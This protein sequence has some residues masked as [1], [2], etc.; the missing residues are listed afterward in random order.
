M[1]VLNAVLHGEIHKNTLFFALNGDLRH[2]GVTHIHIMRVLN[3]AL[4]D[5]IHKN[6][7]FF[8]LN[9]C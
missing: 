6:T 7:L 2:S 5:E 3:A 8:A 9:G 1:R 4:H